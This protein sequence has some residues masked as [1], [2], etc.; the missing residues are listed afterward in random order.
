VILLTPPHEML[1]KHRQLR[2]PRPKASGNAF[3]ALVD[4]LNDGNNLSFNGGDE[5][6]DGS[7]DNTVVTVPPRDSGPPASPNTPNKCIAIQ[8]WLQAMQDGL[9]HSYPP[10]ALQ[11]QEYHNSCTLPW[12]PSWF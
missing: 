2:A 9:M 3:Q 1:P 12:P 5:N 10:E 4:R 7:D 8:Q 6:T 11:N